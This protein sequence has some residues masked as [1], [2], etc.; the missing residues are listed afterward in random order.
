M[1]SPLP[2]KTIIFM[3]IKVCN[4]YHKTVE[5]LSS[6]FY[7]FNIFGYVFCLRVK[8]IRKGIAFANGGQIEEK[9]GKRDAVEDKVRQSM[10]PKN[11]AYLINNGIKFLTG[12]PKCSSNGKVF[13]SNIYAKLDTKIMR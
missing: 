11:Y 9:N 4:R 1:Q 7:S 6:P 12:I 5:R 13:G 2:P 3:S 10:I 8:N